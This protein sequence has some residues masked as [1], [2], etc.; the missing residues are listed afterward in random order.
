MTAVWEPKNGGGFGLKAAGDGASAQ[1]QYSELSRIGR[2]VEDPKRR[3]V[4]LDGRIERGSRIGT[5]SRSERLDTNEPAQRIALSSAASGARINVR[6]IWTNIICDKRWFYE[7][8]SN[9]LGSKDIQ[10]KSV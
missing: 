6:K 2:V 1:V 10:I 4:L 7:Q 5:N 8:Y 9:D 3:Q